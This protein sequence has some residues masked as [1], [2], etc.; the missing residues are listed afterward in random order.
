MGKLAATMSFLWFCWRVH[1]NQ[2]VFHGPPHGELHAV[3]KLNFPPEY[4]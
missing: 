2:L 1:Y 4:P 3:D